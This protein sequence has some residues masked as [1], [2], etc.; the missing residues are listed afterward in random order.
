[1][2]I[3]LDLGFQRTQKNYGGKFKIHLPH[4]RPQKAKKNPDMKLTSAQEKNN[5]QHARTR[6][7]IEHAIGGLKAFHCLTHRIKNYPDSLI[8]C[9]FWITAGFYNLNI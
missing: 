2:D 1:M 7:P 5:R 8:E 4:K 3:W 9:F 6:L